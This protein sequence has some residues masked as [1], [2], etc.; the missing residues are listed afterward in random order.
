MRRWILA[1]LAAACLAAW[2]VLGWLLIPGLDRPKEVLPTRY[3]LPGATPTM[4]PSRT[5]TATV[6]P[7]ATL[8]MTLTAS[9]TPTLTATATATLEARLAVR[10]LT[11]QW[12]MPG[13]PV[14]PTA[15]PFPPGT[16]LLPAP[17]LPLEPLPDATLQA[18]PYTGWMSFESDHPGVIYA[19]PWERR[20]VRE[21][22]QGQYHRTDDTRTSVSFQFEGEGLRLRYVAAR[23]MGLFEILVDGQVIDTVDAYASD[24]N[25]PGTAVYMLGSGSHL[26]VIRPTGRQ[27]PS[28][29]GSA[30][31][32]DAIQVF[33]AD[34]HTL[35]LSPQT[36]THTPEVLPVEVERVSA[37]ATPVPLATPLPLRPV[38][39]RL[40]I[41]WDENLNR[42][43]DPAEGVAG[44]PVR[45]VL[46]G[47]NQV[48]ATAFTD[49][50]GFAQ[51]EAVPEGDVRLVVPYLGK[52]WE[53]RR[54]GNGPVSFSLLLP[55]VNLPGLI[56]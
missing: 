13:V 29:Q 20:Q 19:T 27:H 17:P 16:V 12:A 42:A 4:R 53:V 11:I 2:A 18:P 50:R 43:V 39:V 6:T 56:P 37:P 38:Q 31:G 54:G 28:S 7:S 15:T 22:S 36:P 33:R 49:E 40:V 10:V 21:A 45:L 14:A 48:I 47:S 52:V 32:L 23:N 25:F 8:T 9:F 44:L 30:V 5:P 46:V 24:L 26:L 51:I 41:A 55:P 35:I 3:V 1:G 34:A